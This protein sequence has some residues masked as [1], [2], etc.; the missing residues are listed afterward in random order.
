MTI[1]D[2]PE[3]IEF[4]QFLARKSALSLEVKTGLRFSRRGS[5]WN[6][7]KDV[8]GLKG[9]KERVLA[10]M[11]EIAEKGLRKCDRCGASFGLSDLAEIPAPLDGH[12][13][14]IPSAN[15][16]TETNWLIHQSCMIEGEEIA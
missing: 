4:Y 2:T 13:M 7:C 14:P 11:E 1:I 9:N 6:I 10:Q 12:N 16:T 8:Y 5:V 3:G 15:G